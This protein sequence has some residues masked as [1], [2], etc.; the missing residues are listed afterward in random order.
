VYLFVPTIKGGLADI[1]GQEMPEDADH[2]WRA[3][4]GQTMELQ[5]VPGDHFTMMIGNSAAQ[6]ARKLTSLMQF[7]GSNSGSRVTV[8]PA[9]A[10]RR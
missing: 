9:A 6:L 4:V 3:E 8:T 5:E 2:G 10:P 1:S 7:A